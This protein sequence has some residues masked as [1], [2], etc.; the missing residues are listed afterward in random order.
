MLTGWQFWIDRGGTFTD[1][2]AR[3]PDGTFDSIKLLSENPQ[4][5]PDAATAGIRSLLDLPLD[6]Q[7]P[8][9]MLAGVKMGTTVAT[10]ALLERQGARVLLVVD[11]GF[12]DLLVI[13]DQTRPDLFALDIRRHAPFY[14]AV[15]EVGGR[16]GAEGEAISVLDE[17]AAAAMFAR[18]RASGIR[19]C[20]IA[21][22]H[23]WKYPAA[24]RRLAALAAQAG[25]AQISTSHGTSS[26][27]GLVS[28]ASTTVVDA[29]LS[30]VLRDYV[31]R[32]E[33]QLG[34]APLYFMQSSGGLTTPDK[35]H[36]KDAILSGP[37]GG[38]VGAARTAEAAG[39]GRI[40]G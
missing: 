26:L 7:I 35:F 27:V 40:I 23:G 32:V 31:G 39:F 30:P 25:F 28:R 37:A 33:A 13:G 20:A 2:I 16:V 24:E 9:D 38:V 14:E 34:D 12:G 29:Y 3:R 18:H 17:D 36:G 5:Y 21:L 6:A 10:N 15:E 19:A 1:I 4:R 22:T 8:V 11:A